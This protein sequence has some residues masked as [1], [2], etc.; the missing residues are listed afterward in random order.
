MTWVKRSSKFDA[1][2]DILR[3]PVEDPAVWKAADHADPDKWIYRFTPAEIAELETAAGQVIAEGR[4][5]TGFGKDEFELPTLGPVLADLLD[6]LADGRGFVFLRGLDVSRYDRVTLQA[7]YWGVCAHFGYGIT[8]NA[9]GE[10]MSAVTDYGD[11]Y[12]GDDPYRH[13]I[14]FHR[15]TVEIHPHTDSCDF[16]ALLCERPAKRGGESAVVS[17]LAMY[18]RILA[19]HPEY[20]A[21]LCEG[22]HLDLVG[23]GTTAKELSHHRIPVF[24]W[25]GG[26]M[27]ARFN[28][29]Q[30]ELGAEK[31]AGGLDELSQAAID[32]VRDISMHDEFR[33]AMEF[34][35]G[36]IQVLNNRV[37][38]HSR[39]RI[40]DFDE[41]EKK[42]LLWRVWLN[43]LRPRP[44]AP[45]FANQLNTGAR[46]GVTRR[47]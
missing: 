41:P 44:M 35:A 13:N 28:K 29:R 23:K 4:S 37:T 33:L 46:G 6:V 10:M 32:Y 7:I 17:S 21:P 39:S 38:F 1:M 14:R 9:A 42:R 16:V 11:K 45:E 8:Q 5:L 26:K 47:L 3:Y 19:E 2:I 22:F 15:T 40:E 24:S 27:S 30:I 20:L 36:D 18:N 12:E 31:H 25:F 34:Q 43:A